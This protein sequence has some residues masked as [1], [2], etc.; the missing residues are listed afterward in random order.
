MIK[1]NKDLYNLKAKD[2]FIKEKD[3]LI[4]M[5]EEVKEWIKQAGKDL[6]T[7]KHSLKDKDYYASSFWCQQSI[8][9]GFK[10]LS[11]KNTE[12]FPKI[13]DLKQLAELNN[14]PEEIVELS[15]KINPAYIAARYPDV[16]A[17]YNKKNTEEILK[18]SNL[19][20]KWIKKNLS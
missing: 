14:A 4:Q 11:I 6:R 10:A 15:T 5:R 9:K 3:S 7:A 13:H 2:K 1:A 8:E 16:A 17:K 18:Y 19:V 20:L 12:S